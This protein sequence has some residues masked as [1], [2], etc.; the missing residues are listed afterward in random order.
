M[1]GDVEG[2]GILAKM[3]MY[4]FSS[5]M[6]VYMCVCACVGVCVLL[7]ACNKINGNE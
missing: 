6:S 7:R 1:V 4:Q 3:D 2:R 5:K